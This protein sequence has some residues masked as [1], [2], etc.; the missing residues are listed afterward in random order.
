M[1]RPM[2]LRFGGALYRWRRAVLVAWGLLL[3]VALPVAP[4]VFQSLTAGGFSSPDLEA[5]R[6]SQLLAD[7]FGANPSNFVL[8][9]DDL[10][11]QLSADD[12]RF[13]QRVD[14]SLADVRQLPFVEHVTTAAD[15]P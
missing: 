6:A 5:F 7:R 12:P 4:R 3:L 14:E 8:V 9:Y 11:R 15:N 10:S 2:L 1:R 13:L